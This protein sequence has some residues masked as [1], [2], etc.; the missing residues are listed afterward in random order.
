MI[1]LNIRKKPMPE[2]LLSNKNIL[3]ASK[4]PVARTKLEKLQQKYTPESLEVLREHARNIRRME[5]RNNKIDTKNKLQESEY[6]KS[7]SKIELA[8][9][10]LRKQGYKTP[11]ELSVR[12]YEIGYHKIDSIITGMKLAGFTTPDQIRSGLYGL[13][14]LKY[15]GIS[16]IS[17]KEITS[18]L[19]K[20]GK[21]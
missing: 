14:S 8:V 15:R 4:R 20:L 16:V 10:T 17:E 13:H 18:K 19:M 3:K 12:L 21:K 6:R 2:K 5:I 11:A 1:R 9:P 7:I